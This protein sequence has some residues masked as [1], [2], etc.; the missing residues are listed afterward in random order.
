MKKMLKVLACIWN[1]LVIAIRITVTLVIVSPIA[2]IVNLFR[3]VSFKEHLENVRC[4][5]LMVISN[6]E[7]S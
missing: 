5:I 6:E 3:G 7:E 1:V 2:L 4:Y